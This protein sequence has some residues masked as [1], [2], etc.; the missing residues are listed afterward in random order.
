MSGVGSSEF[1]CSQGHRWRMDD[2]TVDGSNDDSRGSTCGGHALPV[3]RANGGVAGKDSSMRSPRNR[4][5]STPGGPTFPVVSGYVILG[6]LR[7]GRASVVYE[8]RDLARDRRVALEV[9][10][11]G[12]DGASGGQRRFHVDAVAR[13]L[14]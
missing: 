13:R 7:Q 11:S 5:N 10:E 12:Q 9:I 14:Q 6:V 4:S 8:A 3:D 1:L 2:G